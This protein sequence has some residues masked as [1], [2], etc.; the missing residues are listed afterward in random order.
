M[1]INFPSPYYNIWEGNQIKKMKKKK[2]L[3]SQF[4]ELQ[5]MVFWSIAFEPVVM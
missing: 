1:V 5:F 3:S 2:D 4:P